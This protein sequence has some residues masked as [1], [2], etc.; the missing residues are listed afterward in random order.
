M[1]AFTASGHESTSPHPLMPASVSTRTRHVSCVPSDADTT[2][3][4]RR[5]IASTAVIFMGR[6]P[7]V[8]STYEPAARRF[9]PAASSP[10]S[11]SVRHFAL[12]PAFRNSS[13]ST[14]IG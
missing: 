8:G 13:S 9:H 4:K 7:G 2:F 3:G 11:R 1:I 6:A 10:S 12:P 14:S 5:M